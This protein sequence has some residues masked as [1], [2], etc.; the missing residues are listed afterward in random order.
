M[1][2][3]SADGSGKADLDVEAAF[4]PG[5]CGECGAVDA[6]D[7][8]DDGEAEPVT[9]GMAHALGAESLERLEQ[10]V[11]LV[12]RDHWSGVADRYDRQPVGYRR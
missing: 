9:A 4:R 12:G 8:A 1:V 11:Y 2:A 10:A 6:G 5:I 3:N 7:G